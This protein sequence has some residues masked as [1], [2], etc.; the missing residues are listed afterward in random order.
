MEISLPYTSESLWNRNF[1]VL[2]AL[3]SVMLAFPLVH[4]PHYL[5]ETDN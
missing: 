3:T 4:F 2:N 1:V 5:D